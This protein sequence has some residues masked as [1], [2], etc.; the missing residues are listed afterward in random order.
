MNH[1]FIYNLFDHEVKDREAKQ[2]ML[3]MKLAKFPLNRDL[4]SYDFTFASGISVT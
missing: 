2:L 1:A 4:D 3:K